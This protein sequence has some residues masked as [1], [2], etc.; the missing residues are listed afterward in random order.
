MSIVEEDSDALRVTLP[1]EHDSV[2]LELIE[3]VRQVLDEQQTTQELR[4]RDDAEL[5]HSVLVL[6]LCSQGIEAGDQQ[7]MPDGLALFF[8]F[9]AVEVAPAHE[10]VQK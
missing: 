4:L 6:S 9:A 7:R 5:S 10:L 2:I 1:A 3:L 8:G